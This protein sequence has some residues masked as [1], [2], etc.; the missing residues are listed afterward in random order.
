MI[1]FV[2][3]QNKS[4]EMIENPTLIWLNKRDDKNVSHNTYLV[5]AV[6]KIMDD[7]WRTGQ[8][9]A[10]CSSHKTREF[11]Y[12][13]QIRSEFMTAKFHALQKHLH[14]AISFAYGNFT[15][16]NFTK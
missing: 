11:S 3:R 13:R 15:I 9:L 10:D 2:W 14:R 16:N 12:E 5:L 7:K 1:E 6:W 4:L 8:I